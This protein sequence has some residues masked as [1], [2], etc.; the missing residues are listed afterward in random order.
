MCFSYYCIPWTGHSE[1]MSQGSLMYIPQGKSKF[2]EC[3][4]AMTLTLVYEVAQGLERHVVLDICRPVWSFWDCRELFASSLGLGLTWQWSS[5]L[6]SQ[7]DGQLVMNLLAPSCGKALKFRPSFSSSRVMSWNDHSKS[8][9]WARLRAYAC[10]IRCF[11]RS[12][13]CQRQCAW[14]RSM[15]K[16]H[17]FFASSRDA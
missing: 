14:Q 2:R 16:F 12:S 9:V 7:I 10:H 5:W 13:C 3:K 15:Q 6:D 8:P 4:S 17:R 1:A 11:V